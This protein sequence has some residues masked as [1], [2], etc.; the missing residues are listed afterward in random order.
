MKRRIL[1][2]TLLAVASLSVTSAH[3][4]LVD[5]PPILE[6]AWFADEVVSYNRVPDAEGRPDPQF[7]DPNQ[8]LGV[9]DVPGADDIFGNLQCITNP[10]PENCRFVSTGDGGSLTVRFTDNVLDGDGTPEFDLYVWEVGEAEGFDVE[11]SPDGVVWT[12]VGTELPEDRGVDVFVYGFDIDAFGFGIGDNV[13]FVRL[14][15]PDIGATSNPPGSDFDAIGAIPTIPVPAAVWLFG[16][17]LGLLG[18]ARRR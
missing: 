15:S 3:A 14:T 13:P 1:T 11:V 10:S 18:W 16:S 8:A 12:L 2:S 7:S 17:A 5:A 6:D 4:V 9:P